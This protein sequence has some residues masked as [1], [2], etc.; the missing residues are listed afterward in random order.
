MSEKEKEAIDWNEL[1]IPSAILK[2]F[3]IISERIQKL[4]SDYIE[5]KRGKNFA[6][7]TL[8]ILHKL[9]LT[10]DE[11]F[12]PKPPKTI[13]DAYMYAQTRKFVGTYLALLDDEKHLLKTVILAKGK[14]LD[15]VPEFKTMEKEIQVKLKQYLLSIPEL[16]FEKPIPKKTYEIVPFAFDKKQII[17]Y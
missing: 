17:Q 14:I 8:N 1:H 2:N 5:D 16:D 9:V 6:Q 13:E 7:Q 10:L 12:K 15:K 11:M 3:F 4:Q